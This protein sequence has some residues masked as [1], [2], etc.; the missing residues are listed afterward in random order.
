MTHDNGGWTLLVTSATNKGW[1]KDS[2]KSR[3]DSAF[4]RSL[5]FFPAYFSLLTSF[6]LCYVPV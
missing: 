3:Y 2:V 4:E 1:T 6:Y 5:S